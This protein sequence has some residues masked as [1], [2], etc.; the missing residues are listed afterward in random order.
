MTTQTLTTSMRQKLRFTFTRPSLARIGAGLGAAAERVLPRL[1]VLVADYLLVFTTATVVIP[2]LG[3]WLHQSSGA[4]QD[5]L[6]LSGTVAMWLMPLLFLVTVL[7]V[8][9]L[10]VMRGMWR[11]STRVIDKAVAQ[12]AIRAD[13]AAAL[14]DIPAKH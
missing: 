13:L 2:T 7:T 6:T 12:R 14:G 4:A 11:W 9:V 8:G 5:S 3:A 1:L 10:V